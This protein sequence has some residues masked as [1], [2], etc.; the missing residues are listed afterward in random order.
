MISLQRSACACGAYI[1]CLNIMQLLTLHDSLVL[2]L[3]SHSS[4]L[5]N[6]VVYESRGPNIDE[7]VLMVLNAACPFFIIIW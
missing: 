4:S 3:G 7:V 5:L 2:L 1:S 6:G